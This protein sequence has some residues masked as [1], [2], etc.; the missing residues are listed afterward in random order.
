MSCVCTYFVKLLLMSKNLL[1]KLSPKQ[2]EI[3]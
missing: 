2:Y 1:I 3:L